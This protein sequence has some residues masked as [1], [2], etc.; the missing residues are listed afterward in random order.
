[1]FVTQANLEVVHRSVLR[2]EGSGFINTDGKLECM[3]VCLAFSSV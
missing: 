1:M 2:D 3:F